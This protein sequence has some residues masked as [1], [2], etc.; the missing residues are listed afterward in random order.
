[1][2]NRKIKFYG[3]QPIPQRFE[4]GLVGEHNIESLTFV[5]LPVIANGQ[6][7]ILYLVLPQGDAVDAHL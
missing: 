5:D 2:A 4:V 6:A 1:M 3:R 7:A